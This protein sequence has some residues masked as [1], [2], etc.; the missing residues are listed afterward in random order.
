ML[1]AALVPLLAGAALLL[2]PAAASAHPGETARTAITR[3]DVSKPCPGDPI[4]ADH[5]VRGSFPSA[6]QGSYVMLPF[7][8]P[9]RTTA[10]R[11]KYCFDDNEAPTQPLADHTLDLG[12]Y[13]PVARAGELWGP[14]QF[15]GWGGSSHPDVTVSAEGFSSESEYLARP[16]G[17][18]PGKTTRGY[19]PG[20]IVPGRWAAELG[21]AAVAGRDY[22]D[23]DG[24]V[25]WRVEFEFGDDPKF[26]D[27]PYEPAPYDTRP[28]RSRRPGTWATCMCTPSIRRSATRR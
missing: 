28:A 15:R 8:V 3:A 1:G 25:A 9:A 10:V 7:T 21:V 18:V 17:H 22:G 6:L 12:L 16:R 5:V 23:T 24:A 11:V 27:E 4:R 2:A 14:E 19:R 13:G 26:A 20:P